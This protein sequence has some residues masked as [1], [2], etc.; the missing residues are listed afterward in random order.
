MS[1]E[2]KQEEEMSKRTRYCPECDSVYAA[3]RRS[4]VA[5]KQWQ[6]LAG[7]FA[8]LANWAAVEVCSPDK[9]SSNSIDQANDIITEVGDYMI[10]D[11][12]E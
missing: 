4:Q 11:E 12:K 2:T 3:F 9:I 6:K 7:Q 10:F 5:E 8:C 1:K